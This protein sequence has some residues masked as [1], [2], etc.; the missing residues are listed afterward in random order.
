[1]VVVVVVDDAGPAAPNAPKPVDVVVADD[2]GAVVPK[3][4]KPMVGV[5][6]AAAAVLPPK[7]G[8]AVAEGA[9][10]K[11]PNPVNAGAGAVVFWAAGWAALPPPKENAGADVA[12]AV[13]AGAPD[14]L[15][16]RSLQ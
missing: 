3:P 9:V 5:V 11:D 2:D 4:P 8:A 6:V 1:M 14:E 12:G 13:A 7:V 16:K 10:D 15:T